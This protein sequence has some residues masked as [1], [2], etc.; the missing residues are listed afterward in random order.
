M[1]FLL[2]YNDLQ[3]SSAC[4]TH[5]AFCFN[6]GY[7]NIMKKLFKLMP[8]AFF[9][10]CLVLNGCSE[11]DFG[12]TEN[13]KMITKTNE[14]YLYFP[15]FN[16]RIDHLNSLSLLNSTLNENLSN[17]IN[18]NEAILE[19]ENVSIMAN[20]GSQT[21]TILNNLSLSENYLID[22]L[23]VE[24]EDL[25]TFYIAYGIALG[26]MHSE[27]SIQGEILPC[28]GQALGIDAFAALLEAGYHLYAGEVAAGW[29]VDSAAAAAFR[30][31]GIRA[32]RAAITRFAGGFI[33]AAIILGQFAYCMA[34]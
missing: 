24:S 14:N 11:D 18:L 8:I 15:S 17:S 20:I 2:F 12:E 27:P 33:G 7:L 9:G 26:N 19:P 3:I 10:F 22:S 6:N 16:E 5:A 31:A 34:N 30:R 21:R 32:A 1:C 25:E 4:K 23:D 28:L 29:A 13:E